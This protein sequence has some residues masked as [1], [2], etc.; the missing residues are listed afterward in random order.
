MTRLVEWQSCVRQVQQIGHGEGALVSFGSSATFLCSIENDHRVVPTCRWQSAARSGSRKD[1]AAAVLDRASTVLGGTGRGSGR[2]AQRL[3][4]V[5]APIVHVEA[6]MLLEPV[7]VGLDGERPHQPPA[8]LAIGEDAYDM[9]AP[10]DLLVQVLPH[11]G[12]FGVFMM[13]A[14]QA[15]ESQRLFDVLFNPTGQLWGICLTI[16]RARRRDRAGPPGPAS[17]ARGQAPSQ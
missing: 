5:L 2:T 11:V 8:T 16:W 6:A 9:A 4:F 14:R 15:M 17:P 3:F 10:L 13:L 12:R 7:L 1:G